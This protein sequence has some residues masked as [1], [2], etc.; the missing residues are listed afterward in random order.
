MKKKVLFGVIA[1]ALVTLNAL[2]FSSFTA[3]AAAPGGAGGGCYQSM[4]YCGWRLTYKCLTRYT[5]ERCRIYVCSECGG[6]VVVR[7]GIDDRLAE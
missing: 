5:A 3:S 1:A 7:P 6:A 2:A 4:G